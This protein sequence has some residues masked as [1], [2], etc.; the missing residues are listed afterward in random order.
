LAAVEH[1]GWF[2]SLMMRQVHFINKH[3]RNL[4]RIFSGAEGYD[5]T[6]LIFFK[7]LGQ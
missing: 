3:V 6:T 5:I 1:V 4:L 7:T 2:A